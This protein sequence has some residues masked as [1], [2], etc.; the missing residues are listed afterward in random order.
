MTD[1]HWKYVQTVYERG[2]RA[3]AIGSILR[4]SIWTPEE[5]AEL[6]SLIQIGTKNG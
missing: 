5:A 2:D 1:D 6:I 3:S 4:G